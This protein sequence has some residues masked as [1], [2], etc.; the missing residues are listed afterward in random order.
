MKA[1]GQEAF[2]VVDWTEVLRIAGPTVAVLL[3]WYRFMNWYFASVRGERPV[4]EKRK[5]W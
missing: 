1:F 5:A 3:V 2:E 4:P